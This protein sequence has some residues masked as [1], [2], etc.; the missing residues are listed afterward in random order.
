VTTTRAGQAAIPVDAEDLPYAPT[1]DELPY[2]DGEQ[3][4]SERQAVQ[5]PL[6]AGPA[7]RYF[8]SRPDVYV[9]ANMI[10][11]FSL[12][13][14]TTRDFRGPDVFLVTGTVKRE[15]K[16]WVTWQEGKG[17]DVV[18]EILSESTRRADMTTKKEVYAS[19][20]HLPEYFWYDPFTGER[21]GF[22]LHGA[23]YVPIAPDEHDGLPSRILGLTLVR[24]PGAVEGIE[25]TWLRWATADGT[26]LP[27]AEERAERAERRVAELEERL[28]ALERQARES[29]GS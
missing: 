17:P 9:G 28:A 15:R 24:W 20:L 22:I 11:Y 12:D 4:E 14:A 26:L 21:A 3:L 6:L 2:S 5:I 13:Q 8:E 18:I 7:K 23:E 27:T 1:E 25:A 19:R 16:S 29:Q 10:V